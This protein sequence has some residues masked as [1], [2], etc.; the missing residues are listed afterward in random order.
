MR[1]GKAAAR[2]VTGL[3]ARRAASA[4]GTV[5]SAAGVWPLPAF[6]AYGAGGRARGE[7]AD[8]P[9]FEAAAVTASGT[10][11]AGPPSG[12]AGAGPCPSGVTSPPGA[13]P[14]STAPSA[15]SP[16]TAAPGSSWRRAG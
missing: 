6:P 8:A 14:P 1:V 4:D 2:A 15:P 3:T 5:F 11:G 16:R 10:A 9:G 7:P 12:T 13:A